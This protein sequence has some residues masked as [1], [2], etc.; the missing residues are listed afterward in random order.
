M[1]YLFQ[2]GD[3]TFFEEDQAYF[4]SR[5]G[6]LQ[7]LLGFDAGDE[8]SVK[9]RVSMEKNKHSS[10]EK[11]EF[12]A[13]LTCPR[14]GNFHSEISAENIRQGADLLHDKLAAQVRKFHERHKK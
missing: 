11:F 14:H 3:V 2:T 10:G 7:K 6:H 9:I 4:E 5:L 8:D 13:T 12:S 1:V